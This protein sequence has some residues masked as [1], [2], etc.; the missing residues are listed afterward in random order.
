MRFLIGVALLQAVTALLTYVALL[1]D[2]RTTWPLYAALALA[3]GAMTALWFG[4]LASAQKRLGEAKLGE[5]HAREREALR[6]KAEQ[7]RLRDREA[8]EKRILKAS[9]PGA[10]SRVGPTLLAGG[11]AGLGIALMLTQFVTLGL[12]ALAFAGGG[13]AGYALR[14]R[15]DRKRLD[16]APAPMIEVGDASEPAPRLAA[17]LLRKTRGA[18]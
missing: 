3:I 5:K 15:Q 1:G 8:A 16:A 10:L 17:R 13:A 14:A 2:W 11:A 12:A 9:K 7:Q 6:V 4:S 18:G